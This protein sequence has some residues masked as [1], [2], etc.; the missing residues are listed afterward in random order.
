MAIK[1][2]NVIAIVNP[3]VKRK[4]ENIMSD[5]GLPV[6]VVINALYRQIIINEGTV[7]EAVLSALK[8]PSIDSTIA[9]TPAIKTKTEIK[10]EVR[11]SILP[12]PKG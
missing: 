5:L 11:Y 1:S 4:A 10:R 3:E 9:T 7:Y 12:C 8:N 2:A 6:S